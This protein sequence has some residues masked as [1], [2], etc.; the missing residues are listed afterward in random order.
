MFPDNVFHYPYITSN[1]IF[2]SAIIQEFEKFSEHFNIEVHKNIYKITE[3]EIEFF[4]RALSTQ[5]YT[6]EDLLTNNLYISVTK[7]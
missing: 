1:K 4:K 3:N 2:P 7:K 6:E 5:K